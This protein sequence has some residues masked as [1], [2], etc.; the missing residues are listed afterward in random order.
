MTFAM[1]CIANYQQNRIIISY[2]K[3][4]YGQKAK[5][6]PKSGVGSFQPAIWFFISI[7]SVNGRE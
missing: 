3:S 4:S 5:Q 2:T 1:P 7:S 6:I